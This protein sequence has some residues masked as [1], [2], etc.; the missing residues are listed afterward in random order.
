[1]AHATKQ[2]R[3]GIARRKAREAYDQLRESAR[4]PD[5]DERISRRIMEYCAEVLGS[6]DFQ[7]WMRL[8]ALYQNRFVEGWIPDDYFGMRVLPNLYV[9]RRPVMEKR[10][11]SR[12]LLQS[13]AIPDV[14]YLVNG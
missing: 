3:R 12:R 1:M 8:Y 7:P 11:L 5:L 13:D 2:P 4:K 9:N 10:T 14:A 6:P